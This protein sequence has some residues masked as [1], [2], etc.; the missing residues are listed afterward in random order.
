MTSFLRFQGSES[1]SLLDLRANP[2]RTLDAIENRELPERAFM[3]FYYPNSTG[4][5]DKRV[6]PFFENPEIQESQEGNWASNS[7]IGRNSEIFTFLGAKSRKLK[8]SFSLTLPHIRQTIGRFKGSILNKHKGFDKLRLKN[9]SK[10]NEKEKK[11]NPEDIL[12]SMPKLEGDSRNKGRMTRELKD[13]KDMRAVVML[14]NIVRTSVLNNASSPNLGPPT[15]ALNFGPLYQNQ[16]FICEGYDITYDNDAGYDM[17]SLLNR[18]IN[19][20][21][22]LRE[23]RKGTWQVGFEDYKYATTTG[24]HPVG[25]EAVIDGEGVMDPG[26]LNE[27]IGEVPGGR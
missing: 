24:D 18:K 8:V 9:E 19:I 2:R 14:T 13:D 3:V 25:W 23:I 10:A 27:F 26:T 7:P 4:T 5:A 15:I 11:D 22:Q 17:K 12:K 6:I 21:L 16:K 20:T 1:G